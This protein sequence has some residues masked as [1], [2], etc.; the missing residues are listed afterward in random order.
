LS[1]NATDF[2]SLDNAVEDYGSAV[3]LSELRATVIADYLVSKGIQKDR[4]E[5]KAW[6]GKKPL[7]KVD[8]DK[9][10]ANVRVE[11]EVLHK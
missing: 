6:G 8:D 4:M 5:I 9:A 2:F 1:E 7:Y 11:I 3:K 10:E